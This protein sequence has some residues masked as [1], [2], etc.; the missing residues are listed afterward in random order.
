MEFKKTENLRKGIGWMAVIT[1]SCLIIYWIVSS[2][3]TISTLQKSKEA[4]LALYNTA[5]AEGM[6][7]SFNGM[8]NAD[9]AIESI[10]QIIIGVVIIDLFFILYELGFLIPG[11]LSLKK[12]RLVGGVLMIVLSSL[13]LAF[14]LV[15]TI[16]L[17]SITPVQSEGEGVKA[18]MMVGLVFSM[19]FRILMIILIAYYKHANK[20]AGV[21]PTAQVAGGYRPQHTDSSPIRFNTTTYQ[22]T[23]NANPSQNAP[24]FCRY[25]GKPLAENAAFCENCGIATRK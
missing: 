6:K 21:A 20:Y 12:K 19:L 9:A 15:M 24:Q 17:A 8:N 11:I 2:I 22:P 4:I 3:P 7:I 5:N 25:C 13:S 23:Q 10:N 1:S 14:L 16:I 18:G